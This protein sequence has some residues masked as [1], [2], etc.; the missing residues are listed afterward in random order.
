ME[1]GLVMYTPDKQSCDKSDATRVAISLALKTDT[2]LET[3]DDSIAA[4]VKHW[5]DC[6]CDVSTFLR[7]YP[8]VG[9]IPFKN[10]KGKSQHVL[11]PI[12]SA[13]QANM[14]QTQ[15][16]DPNGVK[17]APVSAALESQTPSYSGNPK[18]PVE[19]HK[20]LKDSPPPRP[21]PSD[22]DYE[23]DEWRGHGG[24]ADAARADEMERIEAKLKELKA[25]PDQHSFYW[26]HI[27][28][29]EIKRHIRDIEIKKLQA[30]L[31]DLQDLTTP[32]T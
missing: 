20:A 7:T 17:M 6:N 13:Y 32:R 10:S 31:Q 1:K 12:R 5:F 28:D 23:A 25:E 29:I 9:V 3:S 16:P 18:F 30:R 15:T 8:T 11:L 24:W 22:S 19:A 2:N 14:P 27:R 21:P 26:R 4:T